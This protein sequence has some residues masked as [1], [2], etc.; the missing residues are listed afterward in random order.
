MRALAAG[1]QIQVRLDDVNGPVVGTV[2]VDTPAGQWAEVTAELEG[3]SGVHDVYFTY[4][5]PAGV[6]LVEIDNWAFQAATLD[7]PVTVTAST[8]CV[9]GKV[10]VAVQARNDH[11]RA[12]GHHGGDAVRRAVVQRPS[13]RAGTPTSR[14]TP[15]PCRWRRVRRRSG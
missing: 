14:S 4:T 5:G 1:G 7:L 6:D 15:V 8:R 9:G 3:V 10:Y 13:R 11:R 12:G 2:A